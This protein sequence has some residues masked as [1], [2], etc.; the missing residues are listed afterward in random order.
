MIISK[1]ISPLPRQRGADS[2]DLTGQNFDIYRCEYRLAP[3]FI[4][5]EETQRSAQFNLFAV[6]TLVVISPGDYRARLTMVCA[7]P[8]PVK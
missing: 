5:I 3:V 6:L 2:S 8:V 1:D 4:R 7:H